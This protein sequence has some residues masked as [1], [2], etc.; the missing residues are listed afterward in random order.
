MPEKKKKGTEVLMPELSKLMT[1]AKLQ[2]QEAWTGSRLSTK[3]QTNEQKIRARYIIF[4]LQ[5]AKTK[6]I[7]NILEED[8]KGNNHYYCRGTNI[9]ITAE[10]LLETM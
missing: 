1:N 3:Q 9:K 10:F 2:M 7:E 8:R 6:R 5:K 4:N